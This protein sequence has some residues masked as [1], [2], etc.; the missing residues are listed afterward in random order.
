VNEYQVGRVIPFWN[1]N[2]INDVIDD[3]LKED[4]SLYQ[5]RLKAAKKILNWEVE[6]QVLISAYNTIPNAGSH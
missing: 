3:M 5:D 1:V 4:L 2:G 6:E